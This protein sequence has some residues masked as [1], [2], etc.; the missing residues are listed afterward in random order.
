M[1]GSP[2]KLQV[3]SGAVSPAE[4]LPPTQEF[5]AQMIGVCS[6][7]SSRTSHVV[8]RGSR[9]TGLYHC[10]PPSIVGGFVEPE[11]TGCSMN[12]D[13]CR[14]ADE[15]KFNQRRRKFARSTC[16]AGNRQLERRGATTWLLIC[17]CRSWWS[18]TTTP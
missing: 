7:L 3:E 18:M 1:P 16:F 17:R 5:F 13:N 12:P 11:L 15:R 9:V 2:W 14:N 8:N 6:L 10:G 4:T